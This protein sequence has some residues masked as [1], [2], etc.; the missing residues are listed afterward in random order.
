MNRLGGKYIA[1]VKNRENGEM[2]LIQSSK[3]CKTKKLFKDS[4]K[5]Y[6]IVKCI[7]EA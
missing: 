4:L 1:Q 3:H 7:V 6:Y 2:K 5:E